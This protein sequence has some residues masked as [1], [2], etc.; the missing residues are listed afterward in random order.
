MPACRK[1]AQGKG[2]FQ[3]V[4]GLYIEVSVELEGRLAATRV[5]RQEIRKEG[6]ATL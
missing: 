4:E 5:I 1:N 2:R 6:A 3:R